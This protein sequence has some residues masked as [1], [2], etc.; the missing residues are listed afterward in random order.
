MRY[1][2]D[3]ESGSEVLERIDRRVDRLPGQN[4]LHLLTRTCARFSAEIMT[5]TAVAS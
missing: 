3:G 4:N 2:F 1:L 5:G